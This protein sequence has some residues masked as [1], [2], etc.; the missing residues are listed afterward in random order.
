ML[1]RM[2]V[3]KKTKGDTP[4]ADTFFTGLS[5]NKMIDTINKERFT[6]LLSKTFVT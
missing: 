4:N 1:H 5:G 6:V 2:F 3:V